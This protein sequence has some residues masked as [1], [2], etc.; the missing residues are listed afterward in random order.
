MN[1]GLGSGGGGGGGGF[2]GSAAGGP[3][4]DP[5][6]GL[7]DPSKPLRSKLL[8]VPALRA[9][10]M[11]YIRESARSSIG[12]AGAAGAEIPGAHRGRREARH[13]QA[14]FNRAVR[15]CPGCSRSSS[16]GARSSSPPSR[17]GAAPGEEHLESS[18]RGVPAMNDVRHISVTIDRPSEAVYD[19]ASRPEQLPRW[20]RGLAESI[21]VAGSELIARSP[22]GIVRVRLAPRNPF[23]V[24]DHVVVLESGV[25]VH[26]PMRVVPRP[27]NRS[28]VVFSV[29]RQT[30]YVGRGVRARR[31][32]CLSRSPG[33]QGAAGV[34]LRTAS[35]VS[36]STINSAWVLGSICPAPCTST[37]TEPRT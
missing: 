36:S 31:R 29:F 24:L 8:A 17:A 32:R 23:G 13:P 11:T 5:L 12:D 2:G 14:L 27:D 30:G 6:V 28:E 9:R 16:S 35:F 22:M 4:L 7:N 37:S 10:Y 3:T 26:N 19:L 25:S 33:A 21:E 18:V 1:E 15:T 20:A 34:R